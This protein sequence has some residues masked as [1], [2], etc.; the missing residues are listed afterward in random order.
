MDYIDLVMS[1]PLWNFYVGVYD[2]MGV[3]K[4]VKDGAP[5]HRSKVAQSFRDTNAMNTLSHLTQSLD[6]NSIEH[7]WYL[8]KI[9]IN[10]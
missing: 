7:I 8:I 10:K 5:V 3:A 2:E 6:M 1:G 9:G 4:V